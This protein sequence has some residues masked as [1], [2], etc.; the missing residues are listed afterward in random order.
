[1]GLCYSPTFGT[2]PILGNSNN[3]VKL[4]ISLAAHMVSACLSVPVPVPVPEPE[5]EPEPEPEPT[6][7]FTQE[8][9]LVA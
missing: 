5:S 3:L 9:V 4:L 6:Y 7:S 8:V 1:M 2:C